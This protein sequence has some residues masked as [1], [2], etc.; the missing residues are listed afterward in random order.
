MVSRLPLYL[1]ADYPCSYLPGRKAR[2]LV[3]EP[4]RIDH[5][6]YQQL[7]QQGFRRSGD[8]VYRPH[9]HACRACQSLRVSSLEFRPSRAQRRT[10]QRNRDLQLSWRRMAPSDEHYLLFRHYA[11][12]RHRHGGMDTI[13]PDAFS[14]FTASVWCDNWLWELRDGAGRLICGAVVDHLL[15]G[16]SAVYSYFDPAFDKRSP[17]TLIILHQLEQA[18]H[19][20]LPWVYLGY[21]IRG[22]RKMAYKNLFKPHQLFHGGEWHWYD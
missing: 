16:F 11:A 6:G 9:C 12:S 2:N 1:T 14:D 20:G 8:H 4:S 19:A 22:C 18:R 10:W 17:G 21:Y 3:A 13:S 15:D 5:Q 7:L